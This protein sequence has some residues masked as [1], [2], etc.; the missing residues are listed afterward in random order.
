[1]FAEPLDAAA[2]ALALCSHHEKVQR[3]KSADGKRPW[4]H[5][6]GKNS[7]YVRHA[8]RQPRREIQ[9]DRYLH[10]YRGWPIRRFYGD[11]A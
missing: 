9:P 11:L 7:I 8:Y 6:L 1:P 5:R 10:D 2:C 3:A 4:F